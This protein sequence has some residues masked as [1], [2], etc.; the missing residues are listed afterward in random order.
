MEATGDERAA[1]LRADAK[2]A[3]RLAE[4]EMAARAARPGPAGP[5]GLAQLAADARLAAQLQREEEAAAAR[6]RALQS[7]QLEADAALAR[8]LQAEEEDAEEQEEP[9]AAPT[10][11]G[12]SAR[13]GFPLR[14]RKDTFIEIDDDAEPNRSGPAA[15]R[16]KPASDPPTTA[17]DQIDVRGGCRCGAH[18]L[19]TS[20][21]AP[22]ELFRCH[23]KHCRHAHGAPWIG[24]LSLAVAQQLFES[25]CGGLQQAPGLWCEG[26]RAEVLRYFCKDCGTPLLLRA[27]ARKFLTAGSLF[28]FGAPFHQ[29]RVVE[30]TPPEAPFLRNLPPVG[31]RLASAQGSCPCGGFRWSVALPKHLDLWHCHCNTCRRWSGADVQ[32][33]VMLARHT[34]T[35]ESLETLCV[36]ESSRQARRGHCGRCG[37]TL[38]M[39]YFDQEGLVYLA[40]GAFD[41]DA[42]VGYSRSRM[43][44]HHIYRRSAPAWSPTDA[45]PW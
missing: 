33:W 17:K 42:F 35:W 29:P 34:V 44:H 16:R 28:R 15:K 30:L 2:L 32:T 9:Q 1:L 24:L 21:G 14:G 38:G 3:L 45:L 36:V 23:C 19:R 39:E 37:S 25:W 5:A 10:T 7:T 11:A 20:Q 8:R 18:S 22:L 40:A 12:P 31:T 6:S 26:H 13:F 43:H 41:A 4:C 27:G